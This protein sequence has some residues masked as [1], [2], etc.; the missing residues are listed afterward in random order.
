MNSE[1]V[2]SYFKLQFKFDIA[3]YDSV[4]TDFSRVEACFWDHTQVLHLCKTVP[5]AKKKDHAHEQKNITKKLKYLS[6]G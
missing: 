5:G 4:R 6:I 3:D 1:P 2:A